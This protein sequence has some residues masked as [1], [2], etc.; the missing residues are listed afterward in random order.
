MEQ[1]GKG[2]GAGRKGGWSREERG[3][4]QGGK[5]DGA[6]EGGKGDGEQEGERV[7][8]MRCYLFVEYTGE[9]EREIQQTF[10]TM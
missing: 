1:G 8:G 5:G 2:D 6:G 9:Q 3:M 7:T 10:T 4:E